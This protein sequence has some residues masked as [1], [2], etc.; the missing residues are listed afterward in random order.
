MSEP[1]LYTSSFFLNRSVKKPNRQ[2]P[3]SVSTS[4]PREWVKKTKSERVEEWD[5][6]IIEDLCFDLSL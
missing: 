5:D 2:T 6:E 3:V 1:F 4:Q